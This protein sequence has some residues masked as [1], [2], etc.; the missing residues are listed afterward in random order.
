ME[1][2]GCEKCSQLIQR[3][4]TFCGEKRWICHHCASPLWEERPKKRNNLKDSIDDLVFNPFL[5]ISEDESTEDD[6]CVV[7]AYDA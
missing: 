3:S 5:N 1:F 2:I 4:R 6:D 7:F